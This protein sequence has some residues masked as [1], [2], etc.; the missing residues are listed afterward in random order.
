MKK[1]NL[2]LSLSVKIV[3]KISALIRINAYRYAIDIKPSLSQDVGKSTSSMIFSLVS[4]CKLLTHLWPQVHFLVQP[5]HVPKQKNKLQGFPMALR[6]SNDPLLSGLWGEQLK[7]Q[8]NVHTQQTTAQHHNANLAKTSFSDQFHGPLCP[9][10]ARV[11][12]GD[13]LKLPVSWS[14]EAAPEVFSSFLMVKILLI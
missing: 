5:K 2:S 13:S 12:H 8:H 11:G 6:P 7:R 14:R 9:P 3:I 10:C 4:L 1:I